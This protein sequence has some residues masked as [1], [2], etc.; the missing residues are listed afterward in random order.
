MSDQAFT[1]QEFIDIVK[2]HDWLELRQY[3]RSNGYVYAECIDSLGQTELRYFT[4]WFESRPLPESSA[5][6]PMYQF[7]SGATKKG[8]E[9]AIANQLQK[10]YEEPMNANHSSGSIS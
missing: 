5:L 8:M 3:Y 9:L 7:G 1:M 6:M 10:T 2:R 4:G